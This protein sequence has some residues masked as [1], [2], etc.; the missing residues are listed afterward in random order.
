MES[1]FSK[2]ICGCML[3]PTR[4]KWREILPVVLLGTNRQ[5]RL[6]SLT[7]RL[8]PKRQSRYPTKTIPLLLYSFTYI[9]SCAQKPFTF[10]FPCLL[11]TRPRSRSLLQVTKIF[12]IPCFIL[13]IFMHLFVTNQITHYFKIVRNA[14]FCT[15]TFIT[16]DPVSQA[17]TTAQGV[18]Q[19]LF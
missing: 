6:I 5:D 3:L 16:A 11:V 4:H 10:G 13:S 17:L 8:H 15:L 7:V 19:Q 14:K 2:P 12:A 9:H 18:L 1:T